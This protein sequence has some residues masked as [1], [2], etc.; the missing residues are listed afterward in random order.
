MTTQE[1]VEAEKLIAGMR[2]DLT[3][4]AGT[5]DAEKLTALLLDKLPRMFDSFHRVPHTYR[6]Q[7]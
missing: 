6:G 3:V 5:T 7:S 4:I 1:I 2:D